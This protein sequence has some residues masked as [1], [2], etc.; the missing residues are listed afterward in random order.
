M[1][2][3]TLDK[4]AKIVN[5][6]DAVKIDKLQRLIGV[7][8]F[9]SLMVELKDLGMVKDS[10]VI[11][12]DQYNMSWVYLE[13]MIAVTAH[14]WMRALSLESDKVFIR[15]GNDLI[16]DKGKVVSP[17]IALTII[18]NLES[19]PIDIS[20]EMTQWVEKEFKVEGDFNLVRHSKVV[21][22]SRVVPT[23]MTM[24]TDLCGL[25]TRLPR[26]I[27]EVEDFYT[28]KMVDVEVHP[29]RRLHL[30]LKTKSQGHNGFTLKLTTPAKS[31]IKDL[32]EIE[33][34]E[35]VDETFNSFSIRCYNSAR[36]AFWKQL[37]QS[38]NFGMIEYHHP[39]RNRDGWRIRFYKKGRRPRVSQSLL[40]KGDM[41]AEIMSRVFS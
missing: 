33:S 25:V 2:Q 9:S 40:S 35:I 15:K 21:E 22:P 7:R 23:N 5:S 8:S 36:A 13:P 41:I 38:E 11:F 19:S 20:E 34:G 28:G 3:E 24:K 39:S 26:E 12:F 30:L 29:A 4:V 16:N 17:Q 10:V 31:E 1:D 32:P 14:A 37:A 18:S 6:G 27:K